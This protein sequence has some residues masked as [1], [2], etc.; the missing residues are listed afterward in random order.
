MDL[1]DYN[2]EVEEG[3][4]IT[5]MAGTWMS[6]VEGFCGVRVVKNELHIDP[7][8]PKSWKEYRFKINFRGTLIEVKVARDGV[9]FSHSNPQLSLYFKGKL[10]ST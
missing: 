10:I 3:L 7:I 1:D 9:N 5:S 4:H 6:I 8:L 2:R